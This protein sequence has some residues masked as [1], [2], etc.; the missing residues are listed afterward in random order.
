[1]MRIYLQTH[2]WFCKCVWSSQMG[3]MTCVCM[4]VSRT[5]CD[6]LTLLITYGRPTFLLVPRIL[7]LIR[8]HVE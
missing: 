2:V 7:R 8:L 3:E 4:C 5:I 1:M 6:V